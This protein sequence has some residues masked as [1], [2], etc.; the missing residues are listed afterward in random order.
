MAAMTSA[1]YLRQ[2]E[3]VHWPTNGLP[4]SISACYR[5]GILRLPSPI[6]RHVQCVRSRVLPSGTLIATAFTSIMALLQ[7]QFAMNYYCCHQAGTLSGLCGRDSLTHSSAPLASG[8]R[9]RAVN[10]KLEKSLS[11]Y[12][13]VSGGTLGKRD[14][15]SLGCGTESK[16]L[17]RPRNGL[18]KTGRC[19]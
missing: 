16:T 1:P 14:H 4:F 18:Q 9:K 11:K 13:A 6:R 2:V 12:F 10:A 3:S 17:P 7:R 8:L 15:V 5:Y 19:P